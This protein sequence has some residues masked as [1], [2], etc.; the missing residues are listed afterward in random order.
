VPS[1]PKDIMTIRFIGPL[2]CSGL[3]LIATGAFA[4]DPVPGVGVAA[5]KNPGGQLTAQ[6]DRTCRNAGG[7]PE[8]YTH[9]EKAWWCVKPAK[10]AVKPGVANRG[11]TSAEHLKV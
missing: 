7:V 5:G 3:L 1:F 4:G 6:Y 11:K 8:R 9:I 2:L 10:G